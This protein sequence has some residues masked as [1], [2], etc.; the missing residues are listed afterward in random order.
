MP[1]AMELGQNVSLDFGLV[2]LRQN[3][4]KEAAAWANILVTAIS[5]L[6]QL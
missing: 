1:Q 3:V 4:P 6:P 5:V 2:E